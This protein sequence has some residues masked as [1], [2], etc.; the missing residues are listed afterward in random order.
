MVRAQWHS[1]F[2][3]RCFWK[4]ASAGI[5]F[6]L[7]QSLF[8][9]GLRAEGDVPLRLRYVDPAEKAAANED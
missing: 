9:P 6:V 2:R 8:V 3:P 1:E 4:R 7:L 5:G